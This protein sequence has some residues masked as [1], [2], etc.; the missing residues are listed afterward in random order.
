MTPEEARGHYREFITSIG[1]Q[2]LI[3]RYFGTGS[4][5]PKYEAQAWA[6]VAGYDPQVLAGQMQQGDRHLI[7]LAEDLEDAQF[8]LPIT[9]NDRVEIGGKE[10]AISVPDDFTRRIAGTVVAYDLIARGA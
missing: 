6:K 8:S 5:R 10:L 1:E 3:R 2:V 7:V 9:S 4:T